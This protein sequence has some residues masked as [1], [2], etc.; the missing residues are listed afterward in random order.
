MPPDLSD[1]LVGARRRG[2][3]GA[4]DPHPAARG[5]GAARR[6]G[7]RPSTRST[8]SCSPA[9]TPSISSCSGCYRARRRA[10]AEGRAACARSDRRRATGCC[11]TACRRTWCPPI[12]GP[13][14]SSRR[15]RERGPDRRAHASCCRAPTSGASVLAEALREAGARGR[16]TWSPIGCC[17]PRSIRVDDP[18]IYRMLLER[19]IDA[20]TF[21]S[22]ASVRNFAHD[23]RRGAGR[24]PAAADRGRGV[25]A[26]DSGGRGAARHPGHRHAAG[27]HDRRAG[28]GARRALRGVRAATRHRTSA[29]HCAAGLALGEL[30]RSRRPTAGSCPAASSASLPGVAAATP[31]PPIRMPAIAPFT[32]PR[33]PPMIAPDGRAG[34]KLP[35]LALHPRPR[36]PG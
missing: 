16:P 27:I 8:G 17:R 26:G 12:S 15:A 22:A 3:R 4:D 24:G 33:M 11:A 18:D 35:D 28:P 31:P 21:T 2:H 10:R 14:A 34:A 32:P 6:R 19:Q 23:L 13:R 7:R 1:R 30:T 29:A 20:V 9:R 36:A 5:L 25:R